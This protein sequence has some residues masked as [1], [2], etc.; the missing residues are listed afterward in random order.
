MIALI[1]IGKGEISQQTVSEIATKIQ[2]ENDFEILDIAGLRDEE[3]QQA[4]VSKVG[5]RSQTLEIREVINLEKIQA[6]GTYLMENF[7]DPRDSNTEAFRVRIQKEFWQGDPRTD[8]HQRTRA[9]LEIF[10]KIHKAKLP[11]AVKNYLKE[12]NLTFMPEWANTI[13]RCEY[14]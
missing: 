13:F 1:I 12:T 14:M 10:S 2:K 5:F 3:F 8:H 4:L 11:Q 7:G 9:A 6:A